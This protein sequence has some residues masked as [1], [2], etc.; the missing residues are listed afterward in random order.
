MT[1]R[2]AELTRWNALLDEL[3]LSDVYLRREYVESACVLEPGRPTLLHADGTVFAAIVRELEGGRRDVTTPYG[4]GGP[5]RVPGTGTSRFRTAYERWCAENGVLTTFARLHPLYEN[6]LYADGLTLQPLAGTVAWRL[7]QDL[8]AQMHRHH[9][10]VVRKAE[11]ADVTTAVRARPTDLAEFKAL[12]ERTMERREAAAFYRFPAAYW[13]ALAALGDRVVLVE[14]RRGQEL[15]A[16]L[17]CLAGP[18]WLHYHLGATS[19]EARTLGASNLAF[20]AAAEWARSAGHE[21]FHLG[22]GVGGREDSLFEFKLRFD[23][24]GRREMYLGKAV[25]DVDAYRDLAGRDDTDG[26]FPAYRRPRRAA[27]APVEVPPRA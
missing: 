13:H 18:R 6:H 2:E 15:L 22:G 17:L 26:F 1:L 8:R 11:A 7:G 3:G 19:D 4:Y 16:S 27:A 10:R 23:P 9:R 12:Y 5:V 21:L 24:G 14:A 20:L 25:H